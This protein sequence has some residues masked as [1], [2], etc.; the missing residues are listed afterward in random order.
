M[1]LHIGN[2]YVVP[3]REIIAFC[4]MHPARKAK[5]NSWENF[6]RPY[7]LISRTE[8]IRSYIITEK[9]VYGSPITMETLVERYKRCFCQ[10]A[11][12]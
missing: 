9:H 7:I 10:N 2:N 12:K 3:V 1:Y 11:E 8:C 4:K 6:S 5:M